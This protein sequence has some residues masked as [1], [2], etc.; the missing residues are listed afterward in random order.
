MGMGMGMYVY[1]ASIPGHDAR[2]PAIAHVYPAPI[3]CILLI[4]G[5]DGYGQEKGLLTAAAFHA[6]VRD[7]VRLTPDVFSAAAQVRHSRLLARP[8]GSSPLSR[9]CGC[10]AAAAAALGA[11][12]SRAGEGGRGG[13]AAQ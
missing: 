10:A 8:A 1:P 12:G 3:S 6:F 11:R 4:P 2:I 5:A 9:P 13:V 7:H